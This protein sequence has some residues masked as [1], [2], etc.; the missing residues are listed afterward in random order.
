[1]TSEEQLVGKQLITEIQVGEGK[2]WQRVLL[3]P[4]QLD[5]FFISSSPFTH[6]PAAIGTWCVE[7][8]V[9]RRGSQRPVMTAWEGGP[10]PRDRPRDRK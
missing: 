1:M 10:H 2:G 7:P 9:V 6:P 8:T 5:P 3:R 4:W